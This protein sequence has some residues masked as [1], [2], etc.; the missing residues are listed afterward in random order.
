MKQNQ[1][2]LITGC[3]TGIGR[4]LALAFHEAG[5]RVFAS[6]RKIETL[7]ELRKKGLTA[8]A[9]DVTDAASIETAVNELFAQTDRLDMLINNAGFGLMGPAAELRLDDVR[10]QWETNITGP[11]ALAQKVI[12]HMVERGGGRIVNV[13]SVS[14][15][16]ATPFAGAYCAS[17]AALHALSD[18]MRM[19]LAPLGIEVIMLQPGGIVSK[20]GDNATKILTD[21][22]RADSYYGKLRTFIEGRANEGQQ[23]AMDADEFARRVVAEVTKAKPPAIVRLGRNSTRM[24]LLKWLLSPALLDRMLS[25][26]FGL[27]RLRG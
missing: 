5:H 16:M 18:S 14:G 21:S 19:E 15:V 25:K 26:R 4:A 27:T 22:I 7:G 8:L 9:L 2:V 11:L 3:S 20:F 6:A 17:K 23:G 1:T 13:G 24:P 12:P 10:R